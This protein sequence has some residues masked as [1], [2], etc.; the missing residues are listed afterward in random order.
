MTLLYF[1][2]TNVKSTLR[3]ILFL[4]QNYEIKF[5]LAERFNPFLG[6]YPFGYTFNFTIAITSLVTD[7]LFHWH[8]EHLDTLTKQ[9]NSVLTSMYFQKGEKSAVK[10]LI[11]IGTHLLKSPVLDIVY[12]WFFNSLVILD[13]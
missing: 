12:S 8:C 5:R 7:F 6:K 1:C 9:F 4:I 10:I 3:K 13:D 2:S 11:V